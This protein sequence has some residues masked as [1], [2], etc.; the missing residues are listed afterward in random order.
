MGKPEPFRKI[1]RQL[2]IDSQI[3]FLGGRDDVPRFMAGADL[4][5]HPA[6]TENTGTVLIEAMAAGLPVLAT[7]ICGYAFHIR[8]ADAGMLVP[9][10]FQQDIFNNMLEGMITS[11]EK[12]T[13]KR[14]GLGYVS[15]NDVFSMPEKA[16]DV[17]EAIAKQKA[18]KG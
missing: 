4:L 11:P 5:L 6:Y 15:E 3:R 18:G 17:I 1:A 14:N 16:A 13:W 12:E 8:K 10:P 9:S 7:D 2:N